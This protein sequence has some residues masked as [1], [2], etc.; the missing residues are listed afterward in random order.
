MLNNPIDD[1]TG[2]GEHRQ[3]EQSHDRAKRYSA[4]Y[5]FRP[6]F[7]NDSKNWREVAKSV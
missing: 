3:R 7:P 6:G 2:D 4:R 1:L 5:N